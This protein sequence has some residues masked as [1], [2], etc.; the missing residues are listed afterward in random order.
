MISMRIQSNLARGAVSGAVAATATA[1]WFFVIDLLQR[2]PFHTPLFLANS[3]LRLDA[4]SGMAVA[5]YT[6]AH[7]TVFI[8]VGIMVARLFGWLRVR[9]GILVGAVLG[10]LLFDVIFY[11]GVII[12]GTAIVRALG[13]PAVLAGSMLGGLTLAM[14]L[15]ALSDE[16]SVSWRVALQER[17]LLREAVYAGLM[18]GIAVALWFLVIDLLQGQPFFTP[19]A[20]GSAVLYGANSVET[21]V[22]D[23]TTVLTYTGIHFAAFGVAGLAFAAL[24]NAAE[25][26]PPLLLGIALL[27]VTFEA[28]FIGLVAIAA[29]WLVGA[30]QWWAI[31]VANIIAA[32]VM[33][34]YLLYAHPRLREELTHD[35]EEE[36]V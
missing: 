16:P 31:V 1:A 19:A 18:G 8:G 17:R 15:A 33:G 24:M 36:L 20:L 27:F 21:V 22:V 9:P 7:Y 4:V 10:F 3:L 14:V 12:T 34:G 6:V 35:L 2:Q 26:Q 29:S 11:A 30:L 5:L 25:K 28:L 32:V 23:A 13:W